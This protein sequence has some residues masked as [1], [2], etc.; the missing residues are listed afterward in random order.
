[1]AIYSIISSSVR[2]GKKSQRVALYFKNYIAEHNLGSAEILDLEEYNFPIFEERLKFQ[3]TPLKNAISFSEKIKASDAVIIV[4]PEYNG[5]YP[6]SL[7]NVIDLLTD[8]WKKKPVA[9]ATVSAG[10]FG[11]MQAITSLQFLFWKMGAW[12][13]P[14]MFP[15]AT[16]EKSFNED[17]VPTDKESTDKKAAKFLSE[18]NW[19][20]QANAKMQKD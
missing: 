14:A 2:T 17:G 5:G 16:V 18:I 4:T 1:M 13:I 11:G 8:E 9:F 19:C 3:K 6:A 15:T 12:T 10:N 7:K 20:I